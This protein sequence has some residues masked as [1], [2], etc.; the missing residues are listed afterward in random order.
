MSRIFSVRFATTAAVVCLGLACL[1]ATGCKPAECEPVLSVAP[2]VDAEIADQD[3]D[4][5]RQ[6]N[7]ELVSA[8][9]GTSGEFS[10]LQTRSEQLAEAMDPLSEAGDGAD[11]ATDAVASFDR[12]YE[13][14]KTAQDSI[15]ESKCQ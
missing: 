2:E 1:V 5:A 10:L 15:L 14:W 12:A 7:D 8:L 11:G 4:A 6:A 3:W 13:D 9:D